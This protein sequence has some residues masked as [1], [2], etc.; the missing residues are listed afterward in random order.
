ML[1]VSNN[2]GQTAEFRWEQ[3]N[4]EDSGATFKIQGVF[5]STPCVLCFPTNY[6][7]IVDDVDSGLTYSNFPQIPWVGDTYKRWLAQNKNTIGVGLISTAL[8]AGLSIAGAASANP[9]A[10]ASGANTISASISNIM[11]RTLDAQNTPPQVHGQVQCDSLNA[12]TGRCQ[13]TFLYT[14]IRSQFARII[15]EYFSMFGYAT[16][17]CKIPNRNSRPHWNYVK[18]IGATVTGSVPA[19][20]MRKICSIYDKGVTFWKNG[21]EVGQYNLDNSPN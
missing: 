17:R 20:D 2:C 6:R 19:D 16:R 9:L 18:T 12:G 10:I 15:D 8:G 7:G 1:V 3:W 11:G 21:S 4:N 13:F 5:V 14:T